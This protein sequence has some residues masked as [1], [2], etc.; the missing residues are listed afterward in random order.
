MKSNQDGS[1]VGKFIAFTVADYCLALPIAEVLQVV[2]C[3]LSP[4]RKLSQ[5]G[6]IQMGRHTIRLLDLPQQLGVDNPHQSPPFLLVTHSPSRT[7]SAIPVSEP[8]S[9]IEFPL[10]I[11]QSLP[12]SEQP[13]G[14]RAIASHAVIL[15]GGAAPT[16]IF[17]LDL[18]RILNADTPA[19]LPSPKKQNSHN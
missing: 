18:N 19:L 17:L 9:L 4:N 13:F 15:A 3:P 14:V 11:R 5:I 12:P 7:L 2:N 6:L 8:P 10:A 16:T 1:K